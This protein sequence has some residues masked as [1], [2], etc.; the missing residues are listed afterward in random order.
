MAKI[1]FFEMNYLILGQ[2]NP[3]DYMFLYQKEQNKIEAR[4][5]SNDQDKKLY[6]D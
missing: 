1:H 2:K 3:F 6:H 5:K 4:V